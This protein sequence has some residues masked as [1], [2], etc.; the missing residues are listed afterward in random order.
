[1]ALLMLTLALASCSSNPV[2]TAEARWA[3][4]AISDYRIHVREFHSVWCYYDI[5]LEVRSGEIVSGTITAHYGPA[6]SCWHH[7]LDVV[8]EPVDLSVET[9]AQWT[10]PGL[11]ETAHRYQEWVGKENMEI[12]LEF[13]PFGYPLRLAHDNVEAYDDDGGLTVEH[14]EMLEP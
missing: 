3:T 7:G 12:T 1:M 6:Q 8:D 2:K 5:H 9:A 11:F 10:V 4:S 14:F 13:H